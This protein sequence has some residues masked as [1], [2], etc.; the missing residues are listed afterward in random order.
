VHPASV[1]RVGLLIR[2]SRWLSRS[3]RRRN[4]AGEHQHE[5]GSSEPPPPAHRLLQSPLHSEPAPHRPASFDHFIGGVIERPFDW[6][7]TRPSPPRGVFFVRSHCK[8]DS[9]RRT[10]SQPPFPRT[11]AGV[12]TGRRWSS[13][14]RSG[15]A[16]V[17]SGPRAG[18]PAPALG[19]A[20]PRAMRRSRRLPR[21]PVREH[22]RAENPRAS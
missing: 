12:P 1:A 18:P 15:S 9:P 6:S 7:S 8:Q 3:A 22:G 16:G 11:P 21:D 13:G 17:G 10:A 20:H 4:A 14:S 19:A 2:R 5:E